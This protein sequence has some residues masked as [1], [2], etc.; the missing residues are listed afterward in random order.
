[1][2]H[3]LTADDGVVIRPRAVPDVRSL[4][5]QPYAQS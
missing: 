1:M 4:A 3:T 2:H 5:Y